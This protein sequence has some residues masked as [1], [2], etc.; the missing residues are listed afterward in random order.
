M[1]PPPPEFDVIVPVAI[2]DINNLYFCIENIFKYINP[3]KIVVIANREIKKIVEKINNVEFCDE[4][5]LMED[6]TLARIKNI[7]GTATGTFERS[8]WYFQQFLKMAYSSK[9]QRKY[10]LIWDSDTIPLNKI[11]F[12][13]GN[14]KCLF[15]VKTEY[16]IPYFK[17]INKLFCGEVIKL[18]NKSFIAEHMLIDKD[19]M[20][21]MLAKIEN[22]NTLAGR[23]FYE[24]II[25]AIDRNDI[26]GSGF[27]EFET[28]GNYVLTYYPHLYNL[29]ELRTFRKGAMLI[30]KNTVDNSTLKWIST[31]YDII[32]FEEHSYDKSAEGFKNIFKFI[33]SHKLISF[34]IYHYC[35]RIFKQYLIINNFSFKR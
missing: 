25:S 27:S 19:C 21:Q 28:Y 14:G 32:S 8:G 20:L 3:C 24:K 2:K 26:Q 13:D 5:T 4:D 33:V 30:E 17:T 16:H 15:T 7:I 23:K 22:N 6:L 18:I 1:I 12:W 31:D 10:Y 29:R 11:I 9:C 34:R 35:Y